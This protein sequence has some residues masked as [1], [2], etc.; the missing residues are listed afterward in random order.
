[1][2]F[3]GGAVPFTR[4]LNF[5]GGSFAPH[6]PLPCY[7]TVDTSGREVEGAAVPH[8][9]PRETA[10]RMYETMIKLQTVDTIF[11][12]AQRQGRFSF[13]MTSSGEEATAIGSA[14]ALQPEDVVFSQYR[15][16]GVIMYRGF[17]VQDMAHQCFGNMH[18]QGKGRQMP[19]HYGSRALNFHTISSTL[20][21]QLP[22]AV[23]AAYAMKLDARQAVA[24]A[25]FGE[26]AASEGDFHA[27]LNFAAT[28][29]APVIFICRNNGWAI[30]TPATD[31]YRGD[32][33]AGRGPAYGI[34]TLRVD[35]GDARAV[36]NATAEARRIALEQQ[37]PVLLEAMSY[38]SGHHST[39]DD[40]SRYRAAE[41]MR[42]WRARDP[43]ARFQ[44]WLTDQG[45]WDDEADT[46]AR[47]AARREVIQALE[48]AQRAPKPP[49]SS[50][51]ED[52]YAE[53]P[54]HLK[55]QQAEVMAHVHA[56]PDACPSDIPIK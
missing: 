24:V 21:T 7:R 29:S 17:S 31:Q 22:H 11:Y 44:R 52:V 46:T 34:A 14:A 36:F 25:Y 12:E 33:I 49:L 50:M 26:G 55:A 5:K 19:I 54:W 42:Q 41:E 23:G 15:E 10:V 56:H 2:D 32:G 39:S 20:A 4:D 18:E 53:L 47:Q 45:W 28:L 48:A 1:M 13:Y 38:R 51:F 3:P 30:S 8:P 16:Q 35:G 6:A 43:V 40:S 27:A 9:L 37:A